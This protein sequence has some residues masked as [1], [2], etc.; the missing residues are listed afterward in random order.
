MSGFDD[1]DIGKDI[2]AAIDNV[3]APPSP[4][5][6]GDVAPPS[7]PTPA[8][9]D[10]GGERARDESG[11]FVATAQAA[12]PDA[13]KNAALAADP[14]NQGQLAPQ[15]Q[16]DVPIAPPQHW[17]GQGKVDWA[18]L[19]KNVQ[20]AL[21]EDF[22]RVQQADT[23]LGKYRSVVTPERAQALIAETGSVEQGIQKLFALSDIA[24]SRP[25]DFIH[26]FAQQR[27][28]DL[29]QLVQGFQQGE[30]P[31]EA[32]HPLLQ[33]VAYLENQLNQFVQ[34]QT[35][36]A[37]TQVL[38]EIDAFARDQAHPYFNDVREHMGALMKAGKAANLQE[39]YDMATWAVPSV[40]KSLLDQ[41][42]Q[43]AMQANAQKVQ[44]ARS[45]AGSITGSPAGASV[46][47]DEPKRN[48]EEDITH[49]VSKALGG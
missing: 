20:Q 14:K 2:A 38:S 44:A 22:T 4:T 15:T 26:W 10:S 21:T 18:R 37:Q 31:A 9:K 17:K 8:A 25:V 28:I 12:N 30:Q 5:A 35:Q 48:L 46:A 49:A 39:A 23:E 40:R 47:A 36:G 19:P 7:E 16:Q 24:T 6:S 13:A 11:K 1:D 29:R 41:N 3:A 33:K 27:G 45:A 42:A 32:P 34:Q 43:Q